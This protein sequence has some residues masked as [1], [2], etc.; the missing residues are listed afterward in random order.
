MTI[1]DESIQCPCCGN[2]IEW[3]YIASGYSRGNYTDLS[4]FGNCSSEPSITTCCH[5]NYCFYDTSLQF[6][7]EAM[8]IYLQSEDYN[9]IY[10]KERHNNTFLIIYNIYKYFNFSP[11]QTT[12]TLYFNYISSDRNELKHFKLLY[13][14][15]ELL[16]D[17]DEFKNK[18]HQYV[19]RIYKLMGE[20]NR[21]IGNFEKAK[22]IFLSLKEIEMVIFDIDDEY[23]AI[24][25]QEYI[26]NNREFCDFQLE[27][28]AELN[29]CKDIV[30]VK[31][32][33]LPKYGNTYV[34]DT[35]ID[36]DFSDFEHL[37]CYVEHILN[38][39][40]IDDF[41]LGLE[42]LK[43][44]N[45]DL[46]ASDDDDQTLLHLIMYAF[47]ESIS[48]EILKKILECFETL[49][50]KFGFD[51]T[52]L[53][54]WDKYYGKHTPIIEYI[55]SQSHDR[56]ELKWTQHIKQIQDIYYRYAQQ[57][58]NQGK[59]KDLPLE[60]QHNL[61]TSQFPH[62]EKVSNLLELGFSFD[63]NYEIEKYKIARLEPL[64]SNEIYAAHRII[65]HMMD[66]YNYVW[67]WQS[68]YNDY[69]ETTQ[70]MFVFL[71]KQFLYE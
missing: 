67:N 42:K 17:L 14:H 18:N 32:A 33:S 5:C 4:C 7:R 41:F 57:L 69:L 63:V 15:C 19:H 39:N 28:I 54:Y 44:Y 58:A 49:V 21:R 2:N 51:P 61:L 3:S 23:D 36:K 26:Y 24:D 25:I 22:E 27:L 70:E 47:N 40:R 55:C 46:H 6:D 59:I 35:D 43:N 66:N 34:L 1:K 71:V 16:M 68:Y 31:S 30:C 29:N 65:Y 8:K 13:E 9:D 20:Y 50:F 10:K 11:L 45:I 48:D 37:E 60:K 38:D 52:V 64:N 12:M 62:C 53:Y 56:N